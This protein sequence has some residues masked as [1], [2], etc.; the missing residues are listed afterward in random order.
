MAED[1]ETTEGMSTPKKV[2]TGAAVGLATA[3]AV[4][5]G[6]KLLGSDDESG[7][8]SGESRQRSSGSSS[9]GR[10][11]S[12]ASRSRSRTT[13]TSSRAKTGTSSRAKSGTSSSGQSRTTR[14][15]EQLYAQAKRL[16]IEGRS[17]MT[18]AQLERAV[19]RSRS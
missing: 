18:K 13:G 7:G 6:K 17:R 15:K 19:A 16:K 5:V 12:S 11:R 4:G 9:G 1:E 14:T 10:G 2:A 3:A 8:D